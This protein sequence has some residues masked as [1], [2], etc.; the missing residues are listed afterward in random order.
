MAVK[1]TKAKA[2]ASKKPTAKKAVAKKPA[3]KKTASK[4]VATTTSQP[5][6]STLGEGKQLRLL[7][8]WSSGRYVRR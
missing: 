6:A 8:A 4:P 1:K 3:A 5:A 2:K 7:G